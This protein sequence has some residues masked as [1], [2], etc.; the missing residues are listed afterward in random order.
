MGILDPFYRLDALTSSF[1]PAEST[2]TLGQSPLQSPRSS[3]SI[4]QSIS[5]VNH[6]VSRLSFANSVVSKPSTDFIRAANS[7]QA[8]VYTVSQ[9]NS[10]KPGELEKAEIKR[11]M[12]ALATP[13]KKGVRGGGVGN[14]TEREGKRP[15]KSKVG[16]Y[17]SAE[18][19]PE[20]PLR[21]A[22]KLV[23]M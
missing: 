3:T 14:G 20:L 4:S 21:A 15:R 12:V 13:L 7:A 6:P 18:N 1:Q 19:D 9:T 17:L 10:D 22:L 11:K 8:A 16:T 5:R 23:D 2:S